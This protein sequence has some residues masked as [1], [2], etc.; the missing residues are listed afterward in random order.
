MRLVTP[1]VLIACLS[2]GCLGG[3]GEPLPESAARGGEA[4]AAGYVLFAPI[5]STTTYLIDRQGR[6]AHT[7]DLEPPP[8]HS[9]YLLDNGNLLRCAQIADHPV[10]PGTYGGNIQEFSW[11]GELLWEWKIPVGDRLQ[12]HDVEPLPN[13]NVL[14]IAWEAKTLK[15]AVLV[16][17]RRNRVGPKGL[18]SDCVL[19][20]RPWRPD[21]GE[22]VWEWC[23]WDHLVQD[24]DPRLDN[25][26]QEVSQHPERVDVNGDVEPLRMTEKV[27]ERLKALGYVAPGAA[28]TDF[29]PDFLHTNSIAYHPGLDQIV[30]SVP[31]F[32]EIWV[33]D[34]R[35]TTGEAAGRSGDLLY[36]WGNP[37]AYGRG[38]PGGQ[39]LFGQ[40]DARWIP[41]GH[42]GAG[43]LM[44]FNNGSRWPDRPYSSVIEIEPPLALGGSYALRAGEPYGPKQP[45]WEY[46]ARRKRS[47]FAEF[48]SG[49]HRLAGGNTFVTDGPR[50]RF[51]E[52]TASGETVWEYQNPYFRDAPKSQVVDL[53]YSVF[54]ATYLPADHPGLSRLRGR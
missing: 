20:V 18:W 13:G 49:A 42:P 29:D 14:L 48:I 25:Y 36:R 27:L 17:R 11:Q 35:T 43:N 21:G 32:H 15:Q 3:A 44:V 9:V 31:R 38:G 47:F 1:G 28:P 37:R 24:A 12:H 4:V 39:Q 34:H 19:E 5:L 26:V 33:V 6:V 40:H 16:G 51:F 54:R 53:T 52:V 23:L 2:G 45:A 22:I 7:W 46:T 10:F 41:E 30:L 50:G 8:A